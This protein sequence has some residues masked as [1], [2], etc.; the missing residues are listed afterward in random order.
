MESAD[1]DR[2]VKG[3]IAA[4]NAT[5]DG[6]SGSVPIQLIIDAAESLRA[7]GPGD[8]PQTAAGIMKGG[9]ALPEEV[10]DMLRAACANSEATVEYQNEVMPL[11]AKGV[12]AQGTVIEA[13]V[14][15]VAGLEMIVKGMADRLSEPVAPRGVTPGARPVNHPSDLAKG[16]AA[17]ARTMPA[18][19]LVTRDQLH[20]A[21]RR[22][23]DKAISK[24]GD[25]DDIEHLGRA[26]SAVESSQMT[27]PQI[28]K[29]FDISL[30]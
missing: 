28:L 27:V 18:P 12:M 4:G 14:D 9:A 10:S 13:L 24:G 29:Q 11:I 20:T 1:I 26:I 3:E 5:D 22:E 2:I 16:G 8:A 30:G 7:F 19:V 21:L 25:A 17:P 23:Q 15:A 6:V